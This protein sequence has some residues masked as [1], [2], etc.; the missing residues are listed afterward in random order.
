MGSVSGGLSY[1]KSKSKVKPDATS[2]ALNQFR[3]DQAESLSGSFGQSIDR[4]FRLGTQG[5][6]SGANRYLNRIS[7]F[8]DDKGLTSQQWYRD[9]LRSIDPENA[10]QEVN[11]Q[12]RSNIDYITNT[13]AP[14]LVDSG[15]S[16]F[17]QILSPEI[18]N[19][20]SLLGLGRSGANQ[21]AQAKGAASISLPISQLISQLVNQNLVGGAQA[22]QGFNTQHLQNLNAIGQQRPNVDV[23]LREAQLGRLGLGFQA[24]DYKRSLQQSTA[25][26]YANL[27]Q[28][29]IN[30]SPYNPGSTT[31]GDVFNA[32]IQGSYS[33]GGGGGAGLG[34]GGSDINIKDNI[35][36]FDSK[37]FLDSL[38]AYTFTYKDDPQS[39]EHIG[40]MAQELE[41][42]FYGKSLVEDTPK[43]KI[44]YYWKAIAA[45]LACVVDMNK[46]V[47]T[48]ETLNTIDNCEAV[49]AI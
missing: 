7:D 28:S 26:E 38:N 19:E 11:N 2:R 12:Y 40:L 42:T 49:N 30:A 45:L 35:E 25:G 32:Y 46:R 39:I 22:T 31:K 24:A 37:A 16:Y 1:T 4:Y 6:S 13:L 41:K 9:I 18:T 15:S 27:L 21:E 29:F 23:A 33:G 17:N 34:G 20:Y 36:S 48:I 44:V 3:L 8:A 5:L 10:K 47:S 14:S 43:G